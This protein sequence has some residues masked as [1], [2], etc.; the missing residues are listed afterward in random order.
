[1]RFRRLKYKVRFQNNGEG[2][3]RLIKLN[4][5][6]PE[7]LDKSTLKVID[8]YPKVPICPD[9]ESVTYS[10]LDT[11]KMK[12][13]ISFQF[14]NI[15]LP[16]SNQKGVQEKDSTKGFVKYSLKFGKDFHKKRSKSKTVIIF[17]KNDPIITN[18][19][20]SRFS[21]GLS[22]GVRAGYNY[23]LTKD[24]KESFIVNTSTGEIKV[25]DVIQN[26][27]AE[28]FFIGATFSPYKSYRWYFQAEAYI[29]RY[30]FNNDF[31]FR[32]LE[33]ND[34]GIK[35]VVNQ[36]ASFQEKQTNFLLVPASTRFNINNIF[37]LGA[38][39]QVNLR[40]KGKSNSTYEK[41]YYRYNQNQPDL[42][43]EELVDLRETKLLEKDL[44]LH[45]YDYMPFVDMTAGISRIG[46]SVGVRCLFPLKEDTNI[47]QFYA[48]WK[49]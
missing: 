27:E 12:D 30:Q 24:T 10:C 26:K 15:Y 14:K 7:M 6:I 45:L 13:M 3:A 21:T 29:D 38:G 31:G 23:F 18:T 5:A 32:Y 1:M 16:G 37:A 39:V 33:G 49:F 40:L 35:F 28:S 46:P 25:Q 42:L 20:T 48:I 17:D 44:G 47:L 8:M 9:G 2:A 19:A 34:T 22:I 36:T 11:I 43:T 41:R 4:V